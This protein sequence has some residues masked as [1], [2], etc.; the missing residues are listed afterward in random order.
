MSDRV[1]HDHTLAEL[2]ELVDDVRRSLAMWTAIAA[3]GTA[4]GAT[5]AVLAA[6]SAE[7]ERTNALLDRVAVLVGRGDRVSPIAEGTS[8]APAP[9]EA[10]HPAVG[11][12]K[13]A[14][15]ATSLRTRRPWCVDAP[16]A[17]V[18]DHHHLRTLAIAN[19]VS[20]GWLRDTGLTLLAGPHVVT[21]SDLR[22]AALATGTVPAG[23]L[24]PIDY[25]DQ[26]LPREL[27]IVRPMP[28]AG[29]R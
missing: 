10:E 15:L 27:L 29:G 18:A 7:L 1:A 28:A 12:W 2:T 22:R 25:D 6:A 20:L 3:T 9:A 5:R 24:P 23:V 19:P 26:P 4:Q 21:W 17:T 14:A 8:G 16:H 13:A 11:L